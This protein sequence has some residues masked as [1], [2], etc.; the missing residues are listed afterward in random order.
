MPADHS[1]PLTG[2]IPRRLHQIWLGPR[3]VPVQ[4]ANRWRKSHRG[5]AYRLWRE[6]DIEPILPDELRPAWEHY[7]AKGSWHGAADVARVAILQREGGVYVDIDSE[8][9]RSFD[10]A[11]FMQGTLFGGLEFGTPEQPIRITNGVIGSTANHPILT[12]YV[13]LIAQ[14]Q[15]IDSPWQTVG[16]G[17]LT[18]AILQHRDLPGVAILPVRT[19]YPEDKNGVPAPGTDTVYMRQY[20]ATTHKLYDFQGDSWRKLAKRRRREPVDEPFRVWLRRRLGGRFLPGAGRSL[21]RAFRAVMPKPVR[22]AG[23]SVVRRVARALWRR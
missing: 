2:P 14:A 17:F 4:W 10:K 12:R 23:R 21:R 15:S 19:F 1:A 11:P 9:V 3:P 8:P 5:W 7:L 18:E 22:R 13:E 6:P 16:G 20:W